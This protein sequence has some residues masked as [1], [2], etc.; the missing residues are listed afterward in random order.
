MSD[1]IRWG[2]GSVLGSPGL[3]AWCSVSSEGARRS[4]LRD[5]LLSALKGDGALSPPSPSP[6]L[7][8]LGGR[9]GSWRRWPGC[10]P[11][12]LPAFFPGF[13]IT[14]H[15]AHVLPRT[16]APGGVLR[17]RSWLKPLNDHPGLVPGPRVLPE[18]LQSF[19]Q[20]T[21]LLPALQPRDCPI[22]EGLL[23]LQ[24]CFY[25]AASLSGAASECLLSWSHRGPKRQP[26]RPGGRIE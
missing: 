6:V 20:G 25:P 2:Q 4:Q 9:C 11:G 18:Q 21:G 8:T 13:Q 26:P 12:A 14:F 7:E 5:R 24:S 10:L 19:L 3:P 22:W 1:Q 16:R 23:H 17:G 15:L